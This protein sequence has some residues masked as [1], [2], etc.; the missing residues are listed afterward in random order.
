MKR[1]RPFQERYLE[2]RIVGLVRR[3]AVVYVTGPFENWKFLVS[4][5]F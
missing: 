2:S 5:R 1:F 4:R 3:Q